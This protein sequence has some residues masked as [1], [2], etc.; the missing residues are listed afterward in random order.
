MVLLPTRCRKVH[1]VNSFGLAF[2]C[3]LRS[4]TWRKPRLFWPRS[5]SELFPPAFTSVRFFCSD[6]TKRLP[7]DE[8]T[9]RRDRSFQRYLHTWEL[10]TRTDV[11]AL[12]ERG[13]FPNK[14]GHV[15]PFGWFSDVA[16]VIWINFICFMPN[17]LLAR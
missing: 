14:T 16:A 10:V 9:N 7:H 5:N 6:Q 2:S 12:R 15:P 11:V 1:F 8:I 17:T 3:A 13:Q 4:L